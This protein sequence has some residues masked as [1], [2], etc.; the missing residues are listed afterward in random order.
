MPK[1]VIAGAAT[2]MSRAMHDIQY[3]A[4]HD[5]IV[6]ANI[7]AQAILTYRGGADGEE[8]PIRVIQGPR[9]QLQSSDWG[10]DV[11]PVH[12]ELF[13]AEP[14]AIHVFPRTANG[15]VAPIRII[16]GPKTRFDG[17]ARPRAMAVDP[18]NN[19]LV[20]ASQ[21]RLLIFDRIAQG[22]VAPLR[23]IEG[24]TTGLQGVISHLRLHPQKGWIVT[25]LGGGGGEEGGDE[26]RS[27][28]GERIRGIAVWSV[29]DNGNVPPRWLLGGP[30]SHIQGGRL[31]LALNPKAKEVFVGS[32]QAVD[33]Y[34]FPEI[35]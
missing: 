12:D 10:M 33:T 34:F 30:K 6:I 22:D 23:V 24:P 15:D 7:F 35:F 31:T 13:V 5:E 17:V 14:D 25:V 3:D 2:K 18:I 26:G 29:H 19:V 21:Q 1:R 27:G 9:T 28:S 11:D 16:R 32:G 4:V 8:A 20:V